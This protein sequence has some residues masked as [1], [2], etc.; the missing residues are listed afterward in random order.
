MSSSTITPKLR[1]GASALAFMA[2]A[3]SAV[4]QD[5]QPAKTVALEEVVVTAQRREEKLQEVP[6]S[7]T[8]VSA[9]DLDTRGIRNVLDLS[10]V[11]PNV[12]ARPSAGAL[13][14][15]VISMRGSATSQPAIWVDPPI[16]VYLDGVYLG[17][18]QGSVL[19]VVDVERVEVLRG[20]QGTLFGRNTEGGA[21]NYV[22]RKPSGEF[23]GKAE[24]GGGEYNHWIGKLSMDLPRWGILSASFAARK[25]KMD[26]WAENLTGPDDL[27]A[28]D[29]EAYRGALRFD[30]TD[31]FRVDYSYDYSKAD[32]T[33]VPTSVFALSGWSGTFP[34]IFGAALGTQ[35]QTAMAPYVATSRPDK[36]STPAGLPMWERS[37]NRAHTV[38][39][40]WQATD[41]ENFKYIFADR[42][43]EYSDQQSLSGVPFTSL[44]VTLPTGLPPPND[45]FTFPYSMT[46]YY[47]RM[48]EYEQRSHEL[49]WLGDHGR[50]HYVFGLY[51]FE[52]EGETQDPQS[53]GMF[54]QQSA[55]WVNLA[56]NTEAKAVY[57]QVDW[58][59][60]DR[61]TLTAGIRYTEET[62]DGFTHQWR[63]NGYGGPFVTDDPAACGAL[64]VACL[65]LTRYSADFS[66][67]T[68]M[69]ALAFK[70]SDNL[71]FFARVARGF[72]SGGF[73]SELIRPQVTTPYRPEFST[74][75][76]LGAKSTLWDGRAIVN[77]TLFYTDLTD[78]QGTQLVP[79]TTS[80]FLVNAGEGTRKGIELETRVR[81]AEGWTFGLNYGYLDAKY[82]K[83]LDNSFLPGRPIIDTASNRLPGFAPENTIGAVLDGRLLAS[84]F[85][86][87]RLIVDY[88]YL[89]SFYLYAVNKS[90]S[91]PNAGGAYTAAADEVPASSQV[92]ARLLLSDIPAGA[93]TMDLSLLVR[94]VADSDKMNQ[95]IDL[96]MYRT[97]NWQEPRTWLL[98]AGYKW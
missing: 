21:I 25:E 37:E 2:Y 16:G 89:D 79:G 94:N 96:S 87:L 95:G 22:S 3:A 39:L 38:V 43:M 13:G 32:N 44:M 76:E 71:N 85:G 78:Q 75:F 97:A 63:T 59:F 28:R 60:V 20:P 64:R 45:T 19:D 72:K 73:S 98:T 47:D 31:D 30:F 26:G 35:I 8:A 17:K 66:G 7:I 33:P 84:Q 18:A 93:G 6:L 42:S 34:S 92:N 77:A 12:M 80:S 4:G 40:D 41:T 62:R 51:Y 58:E 69:A 24:I 81:F 5:Q 61:W 56:A 49:Q 83:Y 55:F 36:V 48:T 67:T 52:D 70:Y 53:F 91:A 11:A 74:A 1:L 50:L 54:G 65:P 14:I 23:R 57:S 15:S 82:D 10:G 29:Q 27:G 86:D 68:P 90:L 46:A 88:T 9:E